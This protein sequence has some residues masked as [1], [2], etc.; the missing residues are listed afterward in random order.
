M[1]FSFMLYILLTSMKMQKIPGCSGV[2]DCSD[3]PDCSVFRIPGFS[4]CPQNVYFGDDDDDDDDPN[5]LSFILSYV[6][7]LRLIGPI[8]HP[9]ECD[10]T[11]H[12]RKYSVIFSRNVFYYRRT[13]ITCMKIRNRPD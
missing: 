2:P 4:T 9:G 1:W 8:S 6:Y 3:V 10:L 11:V 13:Y 12:P 7:T 5:T